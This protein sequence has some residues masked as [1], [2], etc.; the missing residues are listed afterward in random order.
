MTQKKSKNSCDSD[1]VKTVNVSL[2]LVKKGH[3]DEAQVMFDEILS[4][5]FSNTI[6]ETGIKCCRYWIPRMQKFDLLKDDPEK[7]KLLF[8]E[9]KKFENFISSIKNI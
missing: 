8:D 2:D 1:I 7:G 9:W 3:L 4:G 6:A 5:N